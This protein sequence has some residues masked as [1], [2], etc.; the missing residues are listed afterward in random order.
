MYVIAVALFMI[1]VVADFVHDFIANDPIHYFAQQ[2]GGLLW[3]AAI[4]IGGGLITLAFSRLSPRWQRW[5][6]LL[7]SVSAAVCLTA[8]AGY[9]VYVFFGGRHGRGFPTSP[10]Q[11]SPRR[12]GL[13]PVP[14]SSGLCF[15][16]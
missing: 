11:L 8:L 9:F 3:V 10:Y 1:F 16:G 2:P 5:V 4:A 13:A 12:Y 15:T 7:A 14:H 6:K